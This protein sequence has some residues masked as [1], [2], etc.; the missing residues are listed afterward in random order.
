[1][2]ISEEEYKRLLAYKEIV[3]SATLTY[4]ATRKI[5]E[6]TINSLPYLKNPKTSTKNLGETCSGDEEKTH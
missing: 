1:M 2:E 6:N 3:E 4:I 5:V